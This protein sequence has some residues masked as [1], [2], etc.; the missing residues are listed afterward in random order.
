[1]TLILFADQDGFILRLGPLGVAYFGGGE[2]RA[3]IGWGYVADFRA[4]RNKAQKAWVEI[5]GR[6]PYFQK[7]KWRPI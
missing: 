7:C 3:C 5:S 6:R 2:R 1:V 4:P